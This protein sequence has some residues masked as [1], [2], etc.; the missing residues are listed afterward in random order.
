[1]HQTR[2]PCQCGGAAGSET[3]ESVGGEKEVGEGSTTLRC[4]SCCHVAAVLQ[5]FGNPALLKLHCRNWSGLV[6]SFDLKDGRQRRTRLLVPTQ[7]GH[8]PRQVAKVPHLQ[9]NQR[10]GCPNI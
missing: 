3:E 4:L 2:C 5:N 10:L 1:M 9:I 8:G 6:W 7:V